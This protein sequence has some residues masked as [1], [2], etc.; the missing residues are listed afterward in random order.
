MHNI[1]LIILLSLF[2]IFS[3][4][5]MNTE[6][7]NFFKVT[8]NKDLKYLP[9][10]KVINVFGIKI[11]GLDGVEDVK[12]LHAANIMA[13]YL[14]NDENGVIDNQKVYDSLLNK[15][16][17]LIMWKYDDSMDNFMQN[18]EKNDIDL[19]SGQDLGNDETRISW[20]NNKEG[21]FDASLEE[22][23]HLITNVG[24]NNA[25]PEIFGLEK[26]TK[27]TKAM[28]VAR[29]GYFDSIPS[30]Y[31]STAWYSYD[32]ETCDYACMAT[33]YLYWATTSYLGAQKN[34][35]NQIY[36]EWRLNTK[37]KLKKDVLI[38][39]LLENPKYKFPKIL[40]DGNYKVAKTL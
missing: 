2:P 26:N 40:P 10:K 34:R 33:E 6:K 18:L 20:H 28:D 5:K 36:K 3:S 29:G 23:W 22:I 17:F 37:R 21:R 39:K 24:Y 38:Y 12:M 16:A 19:S 32:D 1:I 14:D 8:Q 11:Y 4:A 7:K 15:N 9:A 25:Y 27:L 35:L 13:Q 31:P 30:F